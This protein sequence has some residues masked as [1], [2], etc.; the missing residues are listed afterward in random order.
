MNKRQKFSL[1]VRERSRNLEVSWN[2]LDERHLISLPR[3]GLTPTLRKIR[4]EFKKRRCAL[5][6]PTKFKLKLSPVIRRTS[7]SIGPGR[8]LKRKKTVKSLLRISRSKRKLVRPSLLRKT[9]SSNN[10]LSS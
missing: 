2:K 9:S 4:E 7:R 8:N 10:S 5:I 3:F 6:V 1:T